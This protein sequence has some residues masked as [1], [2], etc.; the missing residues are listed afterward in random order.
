[1]VPAFV[2]VNVTHIGMKETFT[3]NSGFQISAE[4]FR[5]TFHNNGVIETSYVQ[6]FRNS[7][8][9]LF[10]CSKIFRSWKLVTEEEIYVVLEPFM[11]MV[12]VQKITH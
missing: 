7:M 4:G 12:V 10:L 9:C 6:L 1:M 8:G 11:L 2:W 3:G 5:E